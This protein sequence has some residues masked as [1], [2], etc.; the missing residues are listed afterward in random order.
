VILGLIVGETFL[1]RRAASFVNERLNKLAC[2]S[3][4]LR[5]ACCIFSIAFYIYSLVAVFM[6]SAAEDAI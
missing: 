3:L 4:F 2:C 6:V 5:D 1:E